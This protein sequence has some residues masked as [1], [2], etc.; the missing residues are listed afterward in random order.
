MAPF[1]FA[2]SPAELAE[3]RYVQSHIVAHPEY[4]RL[5]EHDLVERYLRGRCQVFAHSLLSVHGYRVEFLWDR[6]SKRSEGP[7]CLIHAYCVR[8]DGSLVDVRG[9]VSHQEIELESEISDPETVAM[10]K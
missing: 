8:P 10:S 4:C 1:T 5:A 3:T 9:R 6:Q 2:R 7:R